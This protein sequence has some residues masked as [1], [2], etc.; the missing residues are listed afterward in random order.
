MLM[1]TTTLV[2]LFFPTWVGAIDL[3]QLERDINQRL[4]MPTFNEAQQQTENIGQQM[5]KEHERQVEATNIK[6]APIPNCGI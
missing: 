2:I 1:K 5:V 6:Q 4:N 3:N